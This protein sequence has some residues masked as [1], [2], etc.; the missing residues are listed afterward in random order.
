M[1]QLLFY[2]PFT[3]PQVFLYNNATPAAVGNTFGT[4]DTQTTGVNEARQR[5]RAIHFQGELYAV[6]AD[7]I[8][9]KD[10]PTVM[11][12]NWSQVLA[13]TNPDAQPGFG[14]L[15]VYDNNG[16]PGLMGVYAGSDAAN[17]MRWFKYDGTTWSQ[18]VTH[19]AINNFTVFLEFIVFNNMLIGLAGSASGGTFEFTFDPATELVSQ[20]NDLFPDQSTSFCIFKGRLFALYNES[21]S[22]EKKL[23]EY[24]GAWTEIS[25]IDTLASSGPGQTA[26]YALFNDGTNLVAVY[27]INGAA[28]DDGWRAQYTTDGLV[29]NDITTTILPASLRSVNDGGSFSGNVQNERMFPV[30]DANTVPGSLAQYLYHSVNGTIGNVF[31]M[32]LYNGIGSVITL[33]DTGGETTHAIP[34]GWPNAG[35]RIWTAGERTIQI[36]ARS[37]VAGGEQ[38][39]FV[40]Y[41]G[42]TGLNVKMYHALHG[43]PLLIESTLS[44]PV[45]GGSATFNGGSNQVENVA[46]DGSTVYTIVWDFSS[47]TLSVGARVDRVARIFA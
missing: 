37:R 32:W 4:A 36:V 25:T 38:L 39:S 2:N 3:T 43:S 35:E 5:N 45:T 7:G 46:A 1:P 24:T 10:D 30:Y 31:S 19:Q 9:Q 14:G 44:T 16:T 47:D 8:Y 13:F 6:N 27:L 29:W 40:A 33:V 15:Y 20:P 34:S 22:E 23:A 18:A 28:N 17:A 12:G 42:G 21:G 11:T 41:G 26:T